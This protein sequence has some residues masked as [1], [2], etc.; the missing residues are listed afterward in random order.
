[1]KRFIALILA[2]AMLSALAVTAFADIGF[3]YCAKNGHSMQPK[4][5]EV[6]SEFDQLVYMPCGRYDTYHRHVMHNK[7][8]RYYDECA[9]CHHINIRTIRY[10]TTT[11]LF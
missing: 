5:T 8:C 9:Y 4:R 6:I 3:E 10:V 11:C 1:M 7:V 2:L